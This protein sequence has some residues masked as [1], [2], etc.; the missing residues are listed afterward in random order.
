[1]VSAWVTSLGVSDGLGQG[2]PGCVGETPGT[3]SELKPP[4][5]FS[6]FSLPCKADLNM[7]LLNPQPFP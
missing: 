7:E 6:L 5:V 3:S 2:R 4:T 1:M